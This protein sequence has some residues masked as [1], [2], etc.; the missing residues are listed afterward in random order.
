MGDEGS[1]SASGRSPG[2]GNGNPLRYS[3][4]GIPVDSGGWQSTVHGITKS[5]TTDHTR[6]HVLYQQLRPLNI[7][8]RLHTASTCQDPARMSVAPELITEQRIGVCPPPT[9]VPTLPRCGV[10]APGGTVSF[11]PRLPPEIMCDY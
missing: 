10:T 3:C 8:E 5:G 6:V 11:K 7:P 9:P 2:V 1:I 4:L